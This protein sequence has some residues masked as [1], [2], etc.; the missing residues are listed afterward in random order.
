[1]LTLIFASLLLFVFAS[2][3]TTAAHKHK[4]LVKESFKHRVHVNGIRGKSSV[5]R[6]VAAVLREGGINTVG[7][8]T[9]TAA[10]LIYGHDHE[11][12]IIRKEANIAE[13][14]RTLRQILDR[15]DQLILDGPVGTP[16]CE[17]VVFECMAVNPLYQAYLEDKIMHSTIGIITNVR[18]DHMDQMGYTLTEIARSLSSTI[19]YNGHFITAETHPEALAVFRE[20]CRQ[21]GSVF[22]QA[23]PQR[24]SDKAIQKFAHYEYK[25]NVA[26]ALEV[27]EIIGIDRRTAWRGMYQTLPDP[28][29]FHLEKYEVGPHKTIY[30]ANLFAINDRESFV[31]TVDSLSFEVGDKTKRA[32]I[33]NNRQDR[34]ERVAQ[35][36]D[37]ALNSFDVDYIITFGDYEQ[38]VSRLVE[39]SSRKHK[40][41][42]IHLGN[43]TKYRDA[44]GQLLWQKINQAIRVQSCLLVGAVNIHTP[45]SKSLLSL[46]SAHE[47]S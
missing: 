31:Q 11:D 2:S 20:V 10:R 43:S 6:L 25:D 14:R 5:T 35:F 27:A 4:R 37:I 33:L 3:S 29:A 40:P 26:I 7:K 45:Q 47:T 16:G 32:F 34:P 9:G 19:P 36:V 39:K 17:A 8:T 24:I 41:R 46:M 12:P 38:Q 30:W 28:G 23:Q 15:N 18:E 22:H 13:Q 44:D 42:V 1:M 21:R